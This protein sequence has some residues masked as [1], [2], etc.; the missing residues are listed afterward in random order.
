[1]LNS[2]TCYRR[3]S[4]WSRTSSLLHQLNI[5]RRLGYYHNVM[6]PVTPYRL[7]MLF[8]D[9]QA[10]SHGR[11]HRFLLSIGL[12]LGLSLTS[13]SAVTIEFWHP[14]PQAQATVQ[15]LAIR[16]S[17]ARGVGI[18]LRTFHPQSYNPWTGKGTPDL[19]GLYYPTKRGVQDMVERG[20]VADLESVLGRG[21]YANF[22]PGMLETFNIR[23]GNRSGTYGVPLTGQVHL[24]VYNKRA[25]GLAG[26]NSPPLDWSGLMQASKRL[27]R[28]GITPYAGGFGSDTPP[29]AAAMERAYMGLHNLTETYFGRR[30]YTASG[31]VRYLGIYPEMRRAGFTSSRWANMSTA[32]ASKALL[33]GRVAMVFTDAGFISILQ[34]YKP[35][36]SAWGVFRV[37]PDRRA[38]FLP[39]QPG[40]VVQGVVVNSRSPRKAEA[41]AFLRWLTAPEQQV[42]LA[43][44]SSAL[45]AI[46]SAASDSRLRAPLRLFSST[47][48][49]DQAIDL[50]VY[51]NPR[52]LRVFYTGVRKLLAGSGNPSAVARQTQAVKRR[53]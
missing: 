32:S 12:A 41:I 17:R 19:I 39:R 11:L 7:L 51:E 36:F 13:A 10:A 5:R 33:D 26:I 47:G 18:R 1:M 14:W 4:R 2:D 8:Q 24:F 40:G 6:A 20:R 45:P 3:R 50:R 37:P 34:S 16:Y 23:L 35:G 9:R 22:W 43:N 44:G 42:V 15:T 38:T 31:W 29:L 21:W 49:P 27:E 48:M 53:K 28:V 52:V 25:F 46:S 30:P